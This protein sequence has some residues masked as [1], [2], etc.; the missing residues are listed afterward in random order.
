MSIDR[1]RR[2]FQIGAPLEAIPLSSAL[3]KVEQAMAKWR[4]NTEAESRRI[5]DILGQAHPDHHAPE[6]FWMS[7][8]SKA[9]RDFFVWGHNHDFGHGFQRSGAMGD[10]HLE[11]TSELIALGMMPAD[12]SGQRVLDIGCWSGGDL[13]I[14]AGLGG[15]VEAIEEHPLAAATAQA[16]VKLVG[17]DAPVHSFSAYKDRP[18]W[19]QSFDLVYCSGVI[20]HVT[21]PLLLLRICFAYLKPGGRLVIETKMQEGPGAMCSYSGVVERGWNW[22][23]PTYEAMGRW[24]VDAG[25]AQEHIRVHRRPIGRLLASGLKTQSVALP[26]SA[27]FSRPGSWLEGLV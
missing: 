8:S 17:C 24:L 1:V 2:Q 18:E 12:L 27:G 10:R 15:Q 21:D 26:E 6:D 3:S 19:K 20:Y 13:L 7:A 4:P 5:F 23:A 14:L 25:F 22:Y 9:F 11:I 16:L